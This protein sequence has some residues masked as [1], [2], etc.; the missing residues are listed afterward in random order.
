MDDTNQPRA[1]NSAQPVTSFSLTNEA[2]RAA[3]TVHYQVAADDGTRG[4]A[5][6]V[7]LFPGISL[8][9]FELKSKVL[10]EFYEVPARLNLH[11][12]ID[13]VYIKQGSAEFDREDELS[14]VVQIGEVGIAASDERRLVLRCPV[15]YVKG[16][17]IVLSRA[18]RAEARRVLMTFGVDPSA[19]RSLAHEKEKL[20]NVAARPELI[21]TFELLCFGHA[22]ASKSMYRLKAVEA[23]QFLTKADP[24][25]AQAQDS[26]HRR[27]TRLSHVELASRA[28]QIMMGNL[29]TPITITTLATMCGT[30]PT[31]LKEAF[32]ETFG[33]PIYQWYR[34][35]RIKRAAETLKTTDLTIAEV[36][37]SVGYANPSKFTKAFSDTMG[38][39][40][41]AWRSRTLAE[42][43]V[44][45]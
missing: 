21:A 20:H 36:A 42:R 37:S 24:K 8:V 7:E 44:A 11:D 39:T 28:Q 17:A 12:T 30:S 22:E 1:W 32:R 35:Y 31:V 18:M 13:I 9:Q 5:T 23:L 15:G 16:C 27:T 10:G 26:V 25:V 45:G 43:G 4:E 2:H 38:E 34:A 40:P 19:V 29:E 14:S 41:H 6:I 3:N 33:Q